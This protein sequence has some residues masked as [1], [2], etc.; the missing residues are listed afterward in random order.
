MCKVYPC[1]KLTHI[2]NLFCFNNYV[3]SSYY[4]CIATEFLTK[5]SLKLW[6][7]ISHSMTPFGLLLDSYFARILWIW[8]CSSVH[9]MVRTTIFY[10]SIFLRIG[11]LV[12]FVFCLKLS[13]HNY[14]KLTELIFLEKFLLERKWARKFRNDS[15]YLFVHYGSIFLGIGSLDLYFVWSDHKDLKL[16]EPSFLRKFSLAWKWGKMT[17]NGLI[18]LFFHY[19]SIFSW[20]W[21]ISIFW[22]FVWSCGANST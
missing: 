10:H 11:V 16:R 2:P 14:S 6:L 5:V 15:I 20:D 13:D 21:L 9:L 7:E 3:Y 17:Q 19:S 1:L 22:H 8:A 18:C 12:F 4:V